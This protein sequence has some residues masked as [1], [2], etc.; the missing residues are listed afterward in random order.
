MTKKIKKTIVPGIDV[1]LNADRRLFG[2]MFLVATSR[3]L[4]IW[5]LGLLKH[6]LGPLPWPLSKC[7]GTLKKTNIST[8]ARHIESRVTPAKS[9]TLSSAFIIDRRAW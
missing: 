7:E 5:K 4:D 2:N 1:I 3:N 9:I 6:P 8:L